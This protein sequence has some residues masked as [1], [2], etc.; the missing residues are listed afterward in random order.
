V[1]ELGDDEPEPFWAGGELPEPGKVNDPVLSPVG[2][3]TA[4]PWESPRTISVPV[5]PTSPVWTWT[6][7]STPSTRRVTV[8][9]LPDV[10]IALVGT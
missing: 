7:E 9:T 2:R 1:L 6:I 10:V 8:E 3:T 4:S 5:L